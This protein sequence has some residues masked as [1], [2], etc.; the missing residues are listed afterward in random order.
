MKNRESQ[1][2][3]VQKSPPPNVRADVNARGSGPSAT[4][5]RKPLPH[6][7]GRPRPSATPPTPRQTRNPK[8][9]QRKPSQAPRTATPSTRA[10]AAPNAPRATTPAAPPV[11]RPQPTPAV[12]QRKEPPGRPPLRANQT[13]T[14]AAAN[15]ARRPAAPPV[16]RPQP[17]PKVLQAKPALPQAAAPRAA[18]VKPSAALRQT[19]APPQAPR[20]FQPP[21]AHA[22]T[23]PA[24]PSR[25]GVLQLMEDHYGSSGSDDDDWQKELQ[26][27]QAQQERYRELSRNQ[28]DQLKQE[29]EENKNKKTTATTSTNNNV[30][31]SNVRETQ[32]HLTK[33][34]VSKEVFGNTKKGKDPGADKV[35]VLGKVNGTPVADDNTN[36]E[37]DEEIRSPSGEACVTNTT[38]DG[39]VTPLVNTMRAFV[40]YLKKAGNQKKPQ[41]FTVAL[42]GFWGACDGCKQRLLRFARVW[43][44]E[45][46]KHMKSGVRATLT[47][48][49]KYQ[50][51]AEVFE[52]AWGNTTY[53][54]PGDGEKGPCFH[55]IETDV[56]G[57]N[58]KV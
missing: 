21:A 58:D 47:I 19:P 22:R 15:A 3:A 53:G 51:P 23:R 45:A 42:F 4:D 20:Q 37:H 33:F 46:A 9:V 30:Q 16:Y 14:P 8:A 50:N 26:D 31:Q 43:E 32:S 52:R 12:L 40:A 39:E 55:T 56:T 2:N 27:I 24:P 5:V 25:L 44:D 41:S 57:T 10:T 6:E 18:T 11:Y 35:S 34:S 38:A 36:T 13:T 17:A 48:T 29:K 7:Q 1:S 49:Y 54:W 28:K